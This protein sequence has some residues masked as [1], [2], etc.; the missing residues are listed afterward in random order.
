VVL[1]FD[2]S[3]REHVHAVKEIFEDGFMTNL[4][5]GKDYYNLTKV[6]I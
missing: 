2:N 6:Q 4:S 1:D 5:I 3:E